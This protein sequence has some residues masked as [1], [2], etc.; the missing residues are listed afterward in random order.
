MMMNTKKV[1]YCFNCGEEI[2]PSMKVCPY[3]GTKLQNTIDDGPQP[4]PE[5]V[6][7]REHTGGTTTSPA[8]APS[9]LGGFL[10]L[11][12]SALAVALLAYF[13][14]KAA[15][16]YMDVLDSWLP[17]IGLHNHSALAMASDYVGEYLPEFADAERSVTAVNYEGENLYFVDFVMV[18]SSNPRALRLAVTRDLGSLYVVEYV[19]V[20]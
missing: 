5:N 15:L 18:D 19:E 17:F 1:K 13:V 7:P 4:S 10:R 9:R 11:I 20:P 16:R 8:D 6:Q 12:V 3:C 2:K 14:N